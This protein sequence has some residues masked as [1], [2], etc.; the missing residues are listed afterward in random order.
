MNKKIV[1]I[2]DDKGV[3][4]FLE[5]A[6]K[7]EGYMIS[8]HESYEDAYPDLDAETGLVV[9][10]IRLPGIDGLAA[11]DDI[12]IR[13]NV[14]ILIITAYGTKKNAMEAI[15][16]GATDFFVKPIALDELKIVVKRVLHRKELTKEI[17]QIKKGT[18]SDAKFHGAIGKSEAMIEVFKTV[19][20]IADKNLSVL[21]TG[22]TG[23]GKEVIAG[24]IHRLSKR[25]GG[26]VVVNCA[27][28]PDNLLESELFGYEK[29]AFTGAL[30]Q[31]QGR[32]ELADE[33]TIVLDEIGEMSPYLQAKLLRV[34]ENKEIEV[35]EMVA[36]KRVYLYYSSRLEERV[37]GEIGEVFDELQE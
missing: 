37:V 6:L 13:M 23:T 19:E 22:E 35:V 18:V 21:I 5:E 14:P 1:I 12:K 4:F 3:R 17:E 32:F 25:K 24:L 10:D 29:G 9:M 31:K 7:D 28:I 33:G 2:E 34:I 8:S 11:I 36:V 15:E 30:Q 20:K 27:S 16:R 26:F